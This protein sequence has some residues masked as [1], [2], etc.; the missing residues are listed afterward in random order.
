MPTLS[1]LHGRITDVY[2]HLDLDV[3]DSSEATAN[4]WATGGG[5]TIAQVD[6]TLRLIR[7]RFLLRG[8]GLGSFDPDADRDGRALAAA[9][10]F[11]ETLCSPLTTGSGGSALQPPAR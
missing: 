10:R 3:L 9:F 1:A 7:Q 5:L 8:I 11:I 2:V 4:L 6:Q